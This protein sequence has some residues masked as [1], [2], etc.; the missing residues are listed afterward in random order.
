MRRILCL[1]AAVLCL[2]ACYDDQGLIVS[3]PPQLVSHQ[4]YSQE[5][6]EDGEEYI[7]VWD[8]T[9]K[10]NSVC[11][12]WFDSLSSMKTFPQYNYKEENCLGYVCH[13]R[14]GTWILTVDD[15]YDTAYYFS[16]I[17]GTTA[18]VSTLDGYSNELTLC[19]IIIT[20]I[21]ND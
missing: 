1:A 4:W 2:A 3:P 11:F 18:H 19:T 21:K 7:C 12:V 6:N 16:D 10:K 9:A 17:K 15:G 13:K 8:F 5:T 14:G 20:P